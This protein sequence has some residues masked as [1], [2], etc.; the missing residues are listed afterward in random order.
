[1]SHLTVLTFEDVEQ[2][3][4]VLETLKKL[5]SS[6][7]VKIDDA[8]LIVKAESGKV[9]VKNQMDT[10]TKWG[11]V[12]GGMIGLMLASVFF[13]I[14]GIVIGALGGALVG[15]TLN[16]GV[17]KK[18]VRDVTESLK[19]GS[20]AVFVITSHGN[21]DLMAAALRP[22]KGTVYQTTLP[23]DAVEALEDA[24]KKKE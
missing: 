22:Y 2:G 14:A 4:E 13:P 9:E 8:A 10:G 5:Q 15:K 6:G 17:D 23:E 18:F 1:M 12:G 11:A 3:G 20:S 21:P 7:N 24:L 16:L 19:P